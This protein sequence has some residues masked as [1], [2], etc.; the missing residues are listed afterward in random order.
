MTA[1]SLIVNECIYRYSSG[2][3]LYFYGPVDIINSE[4]HDAEI[5][6]QNNGVFST[7]NSTFYNCIIVSRFEFAS[8]E[9]TF[10]NSNLQILHRRQTRFNASVLIDSNLKVLGPNRGKLTISN[11]LFNNT[12]IVFQQAQVVF[13]NNLLYPTQVICF[14]GMLYLLPKT[15]WNN[16]LLL[17][18]ELIGDASTF[19]NVV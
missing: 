10:V 14:V 12:P 9:S 17:N 18:Q 5:T 7:T 15:G 8:Q 3:F 13:D 6:G 11:S 4:M 1:G 2:H 16:S 19:K